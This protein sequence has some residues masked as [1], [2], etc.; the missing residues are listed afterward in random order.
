MKEVKEQCE[1]RIEEVTKKGN[2]AVV[3]RDLNEKRDQGQ[4]VI[5]VF[6]RRIPEG[7]P[8][9]YSDILFPVCCLVYSLCSPLWVW[10]PAKLGPRMLCL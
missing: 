8:T 9:P 4:Q 2:E 3:S 6:L 10:F 5:L 7:I 1:E